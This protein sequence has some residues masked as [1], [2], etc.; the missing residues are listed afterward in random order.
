MT[1]SWRKDAIN[2]K[3]KTEYECKWFSDLSLVSMIRN[4]LFF[5]GGGGEGWWAGG[6]GEI[7]LLALRPSFQL[8]VILLSE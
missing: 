5:G 2:F 3:L 6:E 8:I 1:C 4:F 7:R